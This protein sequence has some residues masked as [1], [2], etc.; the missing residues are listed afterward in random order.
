MP[1]LNS[2]ISRSVPQTPT[3]KIFTLTSVGRSSLG[4][5]WS[6]NL[7]SFVFGNTAIAFIL[8]LYSFRASLLPEGPGGIYYRIYVFIKALLVSG[9]AGG[10]GRYEHLRNEG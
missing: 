4:S 9:G 7:I 6:I 1:Y 3:F 8:R 2:Q 10:H 5:G